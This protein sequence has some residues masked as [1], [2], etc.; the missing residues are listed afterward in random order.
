MMQDYSNFLFYKE[1]EANA[2]KINVNVVMCAKK[3]VHVIISHHD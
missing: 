3:V 2:R 1:N